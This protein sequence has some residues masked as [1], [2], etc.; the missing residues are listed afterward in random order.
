VSVPK[1]GG[2]VSTLASSGPG[3][4]ANMTV[5]EESVYWISGDRIMKVPMAGGPP[6]TLA[7]GQQAPS[8]IAV[9][10]TSVYWG[11]DNL[12]PP[13]SGATIKRLTPK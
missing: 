7:S 1:G 13:Y 4:T 8:A 6:I 11:T 5:D 9:D 3:V 10:A 12:T 2:M